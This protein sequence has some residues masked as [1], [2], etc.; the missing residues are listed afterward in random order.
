[1]YTATPTAKRLKVD[2]V[3]SH[4]HGDEEDL[5]K[6]VLGEPEPA[7]IVWHHGSMSKL[8][9]HFPIVNLD[10]VPKHWPEERFDMIGAGASAWRG[11]QLPLRRRAAELLADDQESV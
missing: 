8:V 3:D 4:G 9:R 5:V 1:M 11:T 2:V 10:E 7:L 6:E